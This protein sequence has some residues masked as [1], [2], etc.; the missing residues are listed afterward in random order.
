MINC[1]ICSKTFANKQNVYWHLRNIHNMET[2][3]SEQRNCTECLFKSYSLAVMKKQFKKRGITKQKLCIY[4]NSLFFDTKIFNKNLY[5]VHSLPPV[6]QTQNSER[7]PPRASAFGGTVQTYLLEANGDHDFLQF[8]VDRTQIIDEIMEEAVQAEPKKVQLSGRVN[9]EKPALEDE[10]ATDLTIHVN[11]KMETVYLGERLT[12]DAFFH[13]FGSNVIES[14]Q[15][16]CPRKWVD[17]E[18]YQWSLR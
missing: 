12:E 13:D 8:M 18:R 1:V 14:V 16:Y 10:D 2:S 5:E 11:S 6:T 9:V 17:A 7:K 15:F 3:M 4:C